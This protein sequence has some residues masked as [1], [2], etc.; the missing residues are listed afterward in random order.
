MTTQ[1]DF[2]CGREF[3]DAKCKKEPCFRSS[4]AP[5]K[6]Q[7]YWWSTVGYYSPAICP[8]GYTVGCTRWESGQGPKV[9]PTEQAMMC[10][11]R[12]VIS[13]PGTSW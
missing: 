11:P 5:P 3:Y 1:F 6:F 12:Y 8:G 13:V 7:E 2:P 10:V 9:E 4:C